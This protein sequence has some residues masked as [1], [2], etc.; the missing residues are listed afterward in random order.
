MSGQRSSTRQPTVREAVL[1]MFR[2]FGTTTIFGNPGSTELPMFRDFPEDFRYVLGLQEIVAVGMADGYAQATRNAG[3]VNLHSATGVG[4]ALGAVFTAN[5]NHAP[6]VIIAGQQARSILPFEPFLFAE[7]AAEFPRPY[8]KWSCEPA[9]AEDVPAAI[10]RAYHTAMQSPRGPTFVSVPVDDWDRLC[11]PV[12][13]RRLGTS[14]RGDPQLLT[15]MGEAL[16]A[17]ARPAF[18]VGAAVARDD[19]W[20]EVVALAERHRA[21]VWAAPNSARNSFPEDHPLFAGF[22]AADREKIVASLAGHDLILVLG[23]PVFTYHVEGSGPHIPEGARLFQLVDDPAVAA[24]A[25]VGTAVVTSLKAGI[26][27]LLDGPEPRLRPPPAARVPSPL[28][29]GPGLTDKYLMQQVALLRP[30]GSIIVEEAPS[31][32]GAMHDYLP[33]VDRDGF[34]TCASGGLGHGL[35]AAIGIALAR[36]REKVIA[37]LGDG[38]S[39]YAIQGLWTAAQLALGITFVI[40]KN[41]RYEALLEFG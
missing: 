13:P 41:R 9:R 19:A 5:K 34:Y 39:M 18:V 2:A 6:L 20:D 28:L 24:W 27:D 1:D 30:K 23:A 32:R 3:L 12:E 4:H 11:D 8:V 38:S 40:I 7:R 22:L 25:P 31:S 26:R 33:I 21:A 29:S 15:E 35:P 16:S 37:L 10:A 36:P 17:C 14:V